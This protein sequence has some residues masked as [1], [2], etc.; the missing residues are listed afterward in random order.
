MSVAKENSNKRLR[1]RQKYFVIISIDVTEEFKLEIVAA[2]S[3]IPSPPVDFPFDLLLHLYS[4]I[5][6]NL[7][8]LNNSPNV[9]ENEQ[10]PAAPAGFDPQW[11]GGHNP[12]NNNGWIEE[13]DEDEVEAE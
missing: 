3:L 2:E 6:A 13:D 12:N 8:P 4:I 5:M 7:P 10:A 1:S 11:I 9:P